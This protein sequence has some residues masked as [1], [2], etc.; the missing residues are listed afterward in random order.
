MEIVDVT[1]NFE[2][3]EE[4]IVNKRK[5]C[6]EVCVQIADIMMLY[7]ELDKI[8]P[9]LEMCM[10]ERVALGQSLIAVTENLRK[11]SKKLVDSINI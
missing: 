5:D 8:D 11:A 9:D 2:Q 4:I 7:D 10:M 1:F 6:D 3:L